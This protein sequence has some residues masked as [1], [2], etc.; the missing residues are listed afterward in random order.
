MCVCVCVDAL[1]CMVSEWS[2]WGH[3]SVTCGVGMHVRRRM[4][5]TPALPGQC[6]EQLEQAE[7]CMMPE[8]RKSH[9]HTSNDHSTG[10][11]QN[12]AAVNFLRV[13]SN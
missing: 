6:P 1:S 8:C 7:K 11:K 5:K 12:T 2:D 13:I 9:T 4:L 3:C 10:C